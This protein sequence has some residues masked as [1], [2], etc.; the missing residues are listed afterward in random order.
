MNKSEDM[1][2]VEILKPDDILSNRLD[3]LT[4]HFVSRFNNKPQFFTRVPG[5]VNLIG[6]HVDYCG[7]S[8]CPMAIKQDVLLAVGKADSGLHLT[9]LETDKYS[10]Y[11]CDSL[12]NCG[13]VLM[14][15]KEPHWYKYF[16]CGVVGTL[17]EIPEIPEDKCQGINVAVWGNIPPASGLSSSSAV[18]SSAVLA[19]THAFGYTM[20]KKDLAL[21]SARAER[22]IGTEGGAMDQAIAFLAKQAA[23][24][25]A[26]EKLE[27]WDAVKTIG[28]LQKELG[29]SLPETL[30]I[31]KKV[32]LEYPTLY[33]RIQHVLSEAERVLEFKSICQSSDDDQLTRLGKLMNQSHESLRDLYQCSHKSVDLL[34]EMALECGAL[35]AR[36]T[37]AGW[38][39]C[40]VALTTKDKVDSFV[41]NLKHRQRTFN[42]GIRANCVENA[43][44]VTEPRAGAAIYGTRL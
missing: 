1:E 13:E 17:E 24:I 33:K 41:N 21:L 27:K 32:L 10:D 11:D 37:G 15:S 34:V 44:F 2:V 23:Q 29:T 7:F 28:D 5:R 38:G 35:G 36:I 20:S 39:G 16:I 3:K 40:V 8:V 22:H 4:K 18:V 42:G 12:F 19:M 25:I 6:D 31:A 26:K 43:I 14:K 30:E 9:N